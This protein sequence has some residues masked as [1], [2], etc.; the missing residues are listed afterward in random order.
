MAA[1]KGRL[2]WGMTAGQLRDVGISISEK[3]PGDAAL[4]EIRSFSDSPVTEMKG[5]RVFSLIFELSGNEHKCT[6]D[7]KDMPIIDGLNSST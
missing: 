4:K 7:D 2:I 3:V 6:I 1:T 5:H